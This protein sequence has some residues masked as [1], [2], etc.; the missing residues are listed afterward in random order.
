MN[1]SKYQCQDDTTCQ[2]ILNIPD[3]RCPVPTWNCYC[4][5][6]WAIANLGHGYET[7]HAGRPGGAE[8]MGVMYTF[9]VWG[10]EVMEV[11][12]LHIWKFF[13]VVAAVSLPFGRKRAMCDHHRPSLWLTL[14][15]CF[16]CASTCNGQCV[17]RDTYDCDWFFDDVAWTWFW[18]E[19]GIWTYLLLVF[20][21][22]HHSLYLVVGSQKGNNR[23]SKCALAAVEFKNMTD[24]H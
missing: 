12:L 13:A 18:V 24:K 4:G 10:S 9:S 1:A 6:S 3:A 22:L 20:C 23:S 5:W 16:C 7:P 11:I 2:E 8:C 17:L 15:R 21:V 19:L 14:R